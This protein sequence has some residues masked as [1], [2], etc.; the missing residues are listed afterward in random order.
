MGR[1]KNRHRRPRPDDRP[2]RIEIPAESQPG[3]FIEPI[4]HTD[5]ATPGLCMVEWG[6]E[7]FAATADQVRDVGADLFRCAAHAD[8]IAS[9][10]RH[11]FDPGLITVMM[12]DVMGAHGTA[13]GFGSPDTL[14]VTPAGS[15]AARRG[16]VIVQRRAQTG[17]LSP[18]EA[19]AMGHAWFAAAEAA[20][21]DCV[22]ATAMEEAGHFTRRQID[23]VFAYMGALRADPQLIIDRQR[24]ADI[25]ADRAARNDQEQPGPDHP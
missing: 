5:A 9:L 22:L 21:S 11:D 1:F 3:I 4:P 7:A 12:H 10:L 15:S 13:N 14:I 19:R 18:D 8:M 20:E 2:H 25:R 23:D 17:I 6:T 24:E 16:T